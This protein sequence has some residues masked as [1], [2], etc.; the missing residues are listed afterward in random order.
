MVSRRNN[1]G[2]D[3][4]LA[5]LEISIG[6]DIPHQI[7]EHPTILALARDSADMLTLSNVMIRLLLN[8]SSPE[9]LYTDGSALA[10]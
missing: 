1:I 7:M 3:P 10:I 6:A 5:L 2:I 9:G 4:C 8:F